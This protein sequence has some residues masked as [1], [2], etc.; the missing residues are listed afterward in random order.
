MKI[1]WIHGIGHQEV[2]LS[3]QPHWERNIGDG[4]KRWNPRLKL[5]FEFLK[6]D[7][8]F[9][10]T[11]Q[12]RKERAIHSGRAL[13]QPSAKRRGGRKAKGA[14]TS[15]KIASIILAEL[16]RQTR[17]RR[18]RSVLPGQPGRSKNLPVLKAQAA[19]M[20]ALR[21]GLRPPN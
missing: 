11:S 19:E 12:A 21:D 16:E 14:Q 18:D 15:G 3:W 7:K 5:Q 6:Y 8:H 20:F 9:A 10:D 4:L 17:V 2:D 13:P 1:L